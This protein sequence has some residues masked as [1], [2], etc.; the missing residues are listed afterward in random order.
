[1]VG[2]DGHRI[3]IPADL[4]DQAFTAEL[5]NAAEHFGKDL[6]GDGNPGW[7]LDLQAIRNV[8]YIAM[9]Y[10]D[11]DMALIDVGVKLLDWSFLEADDDEPEEDLSAN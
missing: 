6:I 8:I 5:I 1:M 2:R 9:Q 4:A 10:D 3:A 11:Q 7:I